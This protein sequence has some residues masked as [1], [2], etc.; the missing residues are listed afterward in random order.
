MTIL[1]RSASSSK[2]H[3]VPFRTAWQCQNQSLPELCK[4]SKSWDTPLL[5]HARQ[6]ILRRAL[7]SSVPFLSM[8]EWWAILRR[9]RSFSTAHNGLLS[10]LRPNPMSFE[11]LCSFRKPR[12]IDVKPNP[13]YREKP[14]N[15]WN[16]TGNSLQISSAFHLGVREDLRDIWNDQPWHKKLKWRTKTN[17]DSRCRGCHGMSE[18]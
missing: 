3:R 5:I 9:S 7:A 1:P 11:S 13:Q 6:Q 4:R 15:S 2:S 8:H 18:S 17:Q 10:G 14:I 12:A 16:C